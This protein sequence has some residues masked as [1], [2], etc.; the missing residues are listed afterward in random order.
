MARVDIEPG[1]TKKIHV[2]PMG[3]EEKIGISTRGSIDAQFRRNSILR[4]LP[5][6]EKAALKKLLERARSLLKGLGPAAAVACVLLPAFAEEAFAE[7]NDQVTKRGPADRALDVLGEIVNSMN[8]LYGG[9]LEYLSV[10]GYLGL[11]HQPC[12]GH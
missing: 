2:Q 4:N 10:E 3:T 11:G 8:P 5:L 6:G 1:S 9:M 12:V 7:P